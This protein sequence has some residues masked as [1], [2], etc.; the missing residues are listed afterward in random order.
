MSVEHKTLKRI[1]LGAVE[2]ALLAAC[3]SP[4]GYQSPLERFNAEMQAKGTPQSALPPVEGTESS[5]Q[6]VTGSTPGPESVPSN[7]P[8]PALQK[9]YDEAGEANQQQ[10]T[11]G[12]SPANDP[13]PAKNRNCAEMEDDPATIQE[14]FRLSQ[15]L[16]GK[17]KIVVYQAGNFVDEWDASLSMPPDSLVGIPGKLTACLEE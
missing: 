7:E 1:V 3:S 8:D 10:M 9:H 16:G 13:D 4:G 6:P 17:G 14:A 11:E 12:I 15:F 2:T 5:T